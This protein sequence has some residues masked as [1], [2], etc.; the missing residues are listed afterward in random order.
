MPNYM[1]NQSIVLRLDDGTT[2]LRRRTVGIVSGIVDASVRD[3]V[4]RARGERSAV[5]GM[6]ACRLHAVLG[7]GE[8][9]H[10]G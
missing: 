5:L 9:L 4:R 8:Q 2:K 10:A 7:G 1:P 6:I 3:E